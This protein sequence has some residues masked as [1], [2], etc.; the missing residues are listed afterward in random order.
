MN[1]N[2]SFVWILLA[3]ALWG[4]SGVTAA[5]L[6]SAGLTP[7]SV[8]FYRLAI[9]SAGLLAGLYLVRGGSARLTPRLRLLI[10]GMGAAQV[11]YQLSFFAALP[12]V[13]VT[14]A[15]LVALCTAPIFVTLLALALGQERFTAQLGLILALALTGTYLLT[16]GGDVSLDSS[17]W[18]GVSLALCSAASYA[19]FVLLSREVRTLPPLQPT[20]WAFSIGAVLLLPFTAGSLTLPSPSALG[21]LLYLGLIPTALSYALFVW[22]LRNTPATSASV[23]TLAEPLVATLLAWLL[24]GETLGRVGLLGAALLMTALT[25]SGLRGRRK[26]THP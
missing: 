16:G 13:G 14:V 21:A 1:S 22:G 17:D 6:Y 20:A 2:Y 19:G 18:R 26:L 4:T 7:L 12:S 23:L 10:F 25:L 11:L 5:F 24:L 15:T 9:A 8:S 3:A